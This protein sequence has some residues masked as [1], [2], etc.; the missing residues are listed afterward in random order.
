MAHG[1][2]MELNVWTSSPQEIQTIIRTFEN[3]G[4]RTVEAGARIN[5]VLLPGTN[6]VGNATVISAI[7]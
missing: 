7:R 5:N 6:Q 4:F 2:R 1:G 3:A